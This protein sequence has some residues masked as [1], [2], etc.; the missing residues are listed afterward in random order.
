MFAARFLGPPFEGRLALAGGVSGQHETA[1]LSLLDLDRLYPYL[2]LPASQQL[3]GGGR[4]GMPNLC[5]V[6]D[7]RQRPGTAQ[8]GAASGSSFVGGHS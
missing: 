3:L 2:G 1:E 4:G 8:V 6:F 5:G 7:V